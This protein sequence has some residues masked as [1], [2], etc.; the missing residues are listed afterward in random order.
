MTTVPG[1]SIAH[2]EPSFLD[3]YAGTDESEFFAVATEHFFD[4]PDAMHAQHPD[5]YEVLSAFY[6]QDPAAAARQC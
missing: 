6:R 5:L 4:R 3:P 2:G 1:S